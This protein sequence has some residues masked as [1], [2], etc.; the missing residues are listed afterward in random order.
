M[1]DPLSWIVVGIKASRGAG[2]WITI[3]ILVFLFVSA[4]SVVVIFFMFFGAEGF[5]GLSNHGFY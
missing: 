1:I 5:D 3:V 4:V 2:I